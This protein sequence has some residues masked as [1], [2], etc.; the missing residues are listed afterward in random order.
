MEEKGQ[1]IIH[2]AGMI[3]SGIETT[4]GTRYILAVFLMSSSPDY[5]GRLAA[6]GAKLRNSGNLKQAIEHLK[7]STEIESS[8]ANWY[9]LGLTFQRAGDTEEAVRSYQK[10]VAAGKVEGY[11]DFD[12]L[13]NL[14]VA[15][16]DPTAAEEVLREAVA[17]GAPP[18]LNKMKRDMDA[19]HNWGVCLVA[20]RRYE[21]AGLIFESIV[22][23]TEGEGARSEVSWASLGYCLAKL[24]QDEAATICQRK[25][26]EIKMVN[27][28]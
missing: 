20:M 22:T 6:K 4:E 5:S 3:H 7:M 11:V 18:G 1:A 13:F 24:G 9:Q 17:V 12:T 27:K 16:K 2:D 15:T 8:A 25:V 10:A 14:G 21:E 28:G 19:K 23:A 26:E